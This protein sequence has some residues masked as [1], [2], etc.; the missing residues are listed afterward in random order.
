[1][2]GTPRATRSTLGVAPIQVPPTDTIAIDSQPTSLMPARFSMI[3]SFHFADCITVA[4]AFCGMGALF[5]AMSFLQAPEA[6]WHLLIACALIAMALVFDVLDGRVPRW[7]G[8]HL[9]KAMARIMPCE[10]PRPA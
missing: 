7:R 9:L 4:N 8:I 2:R 5:S 1:M 3:R 10:L 6:R